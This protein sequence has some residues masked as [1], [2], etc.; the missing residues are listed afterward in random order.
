MSVPVAQ[1]TQHAAEED[2][3]GGRLDRGGQEGG[4][5]FH[6]V[7]EQNA[8][9]GETVTRGHTCFGIVIRVVTKAYF[10]SECVRFF[11][12]SDKILLTSAKGSFF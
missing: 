8:C 2:D 9:R 10:A 6:E 7:V 1:H 12:T 5:G 11:F 4:D 3:V